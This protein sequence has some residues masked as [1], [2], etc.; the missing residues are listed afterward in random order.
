MLAT[1]H[2]DHGEGYTSDTLKLWTDDGKT[3][4]LV[5]QEPVATTLGW[6]TDSTIIATGYRNTNPNAL[7]PPTYSVSFWDTETGELVDTLPQLQEP[8]VK[9]FLSL[10]WT[11]D[12]TQLMTASADNIVR[13]YNWPL[14]HNK[15]PDELLM[16]QD[17]VADM[18]W[19]REGTQV[20]SGSEDGNVVVWDVATGKPITRL[21]A[22]GSRVKTV[23]W[24]S[25]T[26]QIAFGTNSIS[27]YTWNFRTAGPLGAEELRGENYD[28]GLGQEVTVVAYSPD[29]QWLASAG[30]NYMINMW[31]TEDPDNIRILGSLDHAVLSLAWSANSR[32]LAYN[33]GLAYVYDLEGQ[34]THSFQCDPN[35][36]INKVTLSPDGRYLAAANVSRGM[37]IWDTEKQTLITDKPVLENAFDIRVLDLAWNPDGSSLALMSEHTHIEADSE[38][39]EWFVEVWAMPT[40]EQLA[41]IEQTTLPTDIAWSPDGTHL[42][43][44]GSDS[45]IHIWQRE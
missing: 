32:Q 35:D 2:I 23:A 7:N 29:G 36:I 40:G 19:N 44:G 1:L 37:C 24:N 33:N 22:P 30:P 31:S 21:Q 9:P 20:V 14:Q 8:Y 17:P 3:L 39:R 41:S 11:P 25:H 16:G 42:T 12:G 26:G 18:A 4:K 15:M 27:V 6:N 13:I 28:N 5:I 38:I 43:V 10:D 45:L 34:T